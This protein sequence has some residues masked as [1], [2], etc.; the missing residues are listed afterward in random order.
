MSNLLQETGDALL[1]ETGDHILL[2]L[3]QA[4]TFTFPTGKIHIGKFLNAEPTYT[5][6]NE[7]IGYDQI[8][9]G[10]GRVN[11]V[12]VDGLDDSW[13]EYDRADL[14]ARGAP[15]HKYLDL[16]EL[17]LR[18]QVRQRA[19]E[20]IE[21]A[22]ASSSPGGDISGPRVLETTRMDAIFFIDEQGNRYQT[23]IEGKS[24]RFNQSLTP[25]QRASIDTGALFFCPTDIGDDEFI[26]R[27]QFDRTDA[28]TL[29]DA[30]VGG[31][32]VVT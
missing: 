32:W 15:I 25:F 17:P 31:S 10:R 24:V 26:A 9:E 1:Q 4:A 3:S 16:P 30:L 12:L 19:L 20:E 2:E 27:D 7:I 21:Q 23:R 22:R 5:L 11:V 18:G 29:G 14:L 13:T 28:A 8:D 6:E